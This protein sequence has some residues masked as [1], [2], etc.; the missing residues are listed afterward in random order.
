MSV[1]N[2]HSETQPTRRAT[3]RT[4]PVWIAFAALLL[5]AAGLSPAM[6]TDEIELEVPPENL[7][8]VQL[9][10]K[11]NAMR[12][13]PGH[14]SLFKGERYV[15]VL[16]NPSPVTHEF[17]SE[18]FHRLVSTEKLK[19]FDERDKLVAYVVGPIVEVELLPGGRIEWTFVPQR[20]GTDIDL[21]CDIPGH[22]DAGM[23]GTMEIRP[24]P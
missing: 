4:G 19:I 14:I 15:L 8:H 18:T 11:D 7:L 17:A 12:F 22:K 24:Q 13:F 2:G 20:T 23:V 5:L 21:F 10:S 9:G 6:A 16:T 3:R 1:S